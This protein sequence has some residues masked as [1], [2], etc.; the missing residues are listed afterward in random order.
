MEDLQN[1]EEEILKQAIDTV[2]AYDTGVDTRSGSLIKTALTPVAIECANMLS[3]IEW[4]IDQAFPGT[5]ER[6]YLIRQAAGRATPY[7]ATA[8]VLL[9]EFEP[10]DL[11]IVIG[12]RFSQE[13][14]NF[15]VSEKLGNGKY[16]VT[17]ETA[18]SAANRYIGRLIPI[19]SIPELDAAQTTEV[20]IL[21]D[22][23]EDTETFR[24]RYIETLLNAPFG[25][26]VTEYK[27]KAKAIDGVGGV[28]VLRAWNGGGTVGLILQASDYGV[29]SQLL[30]DQ[31][32][33]AF[34]PNQDGSGIGLAP[35]DHAVTVFAASGKEIAVQMQF[36]LQDGYLFDD[37]QASCEAAISD[38][39][40]ALA[41]DWEN[42]AV[43]TVRLTGIE[44]AVLSVPGVID[45]E[46]T[47]INGAA[48]NL[49]LESSEIPVM[50][51]LT[52]GSADA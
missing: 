34:D 50:G 19:E 32:Q 51:G 9:A 27:Q 36:T 40:S 52:D 2:K 45:C 21:G 46:G 37:I 24:A 15:Y 5:A 17:C 42:D 47:T 10:K 3:L 41:K 18:G 35:I 14:L 11:E 8:A 43:I 44:Q 7:E 38:Y 48:K 49:I 29:P 16:A 39:L 23:A 1:T 26:N 31:V 30:I 25:G 12:S 22:D 4:A 33:Q 20:L 13:D 28:K 6:T